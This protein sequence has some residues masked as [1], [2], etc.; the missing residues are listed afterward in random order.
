MSTSIGSPL[1]KMMDDALSGTEVREGRRIVTD[2]VEGLSESEFMNIGYEIVADGDHIQTFINGQPCVD[3][4]DPEGAKRGIIA[5]QLHS[6]G[7]TEIR[8]RN[9][10][11]EVIP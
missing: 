6:G 3:L 9:L 1:K 8:F 11:L 4:Q 2:D 10:Q 5:F 7:P